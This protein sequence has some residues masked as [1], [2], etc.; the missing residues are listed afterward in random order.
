[1]QQAR[2][3][4]LVKVLTVAEDDYR[5][6]GSR[7]ASLSLELFGKYLSCMALGHCSSHYIS[8][9]STGLLHLAMTETGSEVLVATLGSDR[10]MPSPRGPAATN[11]LDA[12]F[13]LAL[14]H[15]AMNQAEISFSKAALADVWSH[16]KVAREEVDGR[17]TVSRLSVTELSKLPKFV[18]H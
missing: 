17:Q 10:Q 7:I 8:G 13:D 1:M 2:D 15:A 18:T 3:G 14:S 4:D 9:L 12:A 6:V 16:R 11:S 5:F